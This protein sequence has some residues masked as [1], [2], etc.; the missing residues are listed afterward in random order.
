VT[1]PSLSTSVPPILVSPGA[2]LLAARK[3]P[4]FCATPA[5]LTG[6]LGT[7][8]LSTTSAGSRRLATED[9]VGEG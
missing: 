8:I 5:E 7:R 6:Q 9:I 1:A 2:Q 4:S 3:R